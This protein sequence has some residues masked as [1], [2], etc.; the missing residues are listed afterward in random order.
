MLKYWLPGKW[1]SQGDL[2]RKIR[3]FVKIE[4]KVGSKKW[5]KKSGV[6]KG[7]LY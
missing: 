4:L 3:T 2:F 1:Y 5:K 7:H 6:K